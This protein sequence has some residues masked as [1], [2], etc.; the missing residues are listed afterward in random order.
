MKITN[1]QCP[2]CGGKLEPMKNNPKIVVCE[3]CKSQFLVEED[4][5][6]NY[7]IHQYP[8]AS[9]MPGGAGQ[10]NGPAR[11]PAAI[12][13]FTA[14]VVLTSVTGIL[15]RSYSFSSGNPRRET[16]PVF[17]EAEGGENR[18]PEKDTE[19]SM[20]PLCRSAVKAIFGRSADLVTQE[21]LDR[22]KYI[23][24]SPGSQSATIEYSFKDPYS[25]P[26]FQAAAVTLEPESWS[27]S[28]L[29]L[30]TGLTKLDATNC[31]DGVSLKELTQLKGLACAG[32][33]ISQIADMIGEPK[34]LMELSL[35]GTQSLEGISVFENLETLTVED[36]ISPDLKQ[37]VPLKNLS[38]LSVTEDERRE[39]FNTGEPAPLTDYSALSV[40]TGLKELE[41]ESPSVRDLGF[42]RSLTSLTH[43]SLSGTEIISLEPVTGLAGLISLKLED[44][45]SVQDYS[46]IRHLTGLTSL[47]IDKSTTQDDPDL[48]ALTGLEN[49]DMSGFISI[50]FLRNMGNLRKLSIHGCNLDEIA[51]ISSLTNLESLTCYSS[52]TYLVPLRDVGFIDSMTNL[53]FLDFCGISQG[54]GW[55][56]YQRN[57]EILGDISNVL[58]HPGLEE[59]YLNNCMFQ[60]DFEKLQE[61]PS[62]QKLELREVKLKENFHVQSSGGITDLWYDDVTL[63]EHTDFLANYPNLRELYLDGNQLTNIQFAASLKNLTHLGINNNYVTELSPLNQA[64]SLKYLDIRQNPISTTI[65]TGEDVRIL[66]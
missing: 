6:I 19:N 57:T 5:T 25:D 12:G 28:D 63:D 18:V 15:L 11:S 61:N 51:A 58:N 64:E 41:V 7:H 60:L 52:W 44:N 66:R 31:R 37:L 10:N 62:L 14:L 4:Q 32:L 8:A 36:I 43:L 21:D 22:I 65:E 50:S 54:N 59:L 33:E 38:S 20:S 49:L 48:S 40:L 3:Y 2:S 45:A 35:D 55:G 23:N 1:L 47:T 26:D 56:G 34:Q 13:V 29:S 30:F 17:A 16:P 9:P 53:R 42:L 39:P 24:I 46:P 27:W